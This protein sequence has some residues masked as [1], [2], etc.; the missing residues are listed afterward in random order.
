ME[1]IK[2][3]EKTVWHSNCPLGLRKE[4]IET[5]LGGAARNQMLPLAIEEIRRFVEMFGIEVL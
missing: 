5:W 1:I 4:P 2:D 3:F